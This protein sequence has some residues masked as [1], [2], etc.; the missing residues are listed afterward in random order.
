MEDFETLLTK[1]I[2]TSLTNHPEKWDESVVGI[3]RDD[4]L[5][6][7]IG[8]FPDNAIVTILRPNKYEFK[9]MK[10]RRVLF[11]LIHSFVEQKQ[12]AK[13]A[14]ETVDSE[15]KLRDFLNLDKFD[16]VK[17]RKDKIDHLNDIADHEP[18]PEK[19]LN[20]PEKPLNLP[21]KK[22]FFKSLFK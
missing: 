10:N 16:L 21:K 19:P 15:E 1:E 3:K 8:I 7:T 22:G 5:Q 12:A 13:K 14:K 4:G 18:E 11:D 17:S 20:L 6:L 9:D 2:V